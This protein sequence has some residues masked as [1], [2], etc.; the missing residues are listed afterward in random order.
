MTDEAYK[1]HVFLREIRKLSILM[2][3]SELEQKDWF[4][5]AQGCGSYSSEL[6]VQS[7][8]KG[9]AMEAAIVKLVE[10]EEEHERMLGD[11]LAK[12]QTALAM[13]EDLTADEISILKLYY[14]HRYT[15]ESISGIIHLSRQRVNQIR[16]QAL[17]SIGRKMA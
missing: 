6:K 16:H 8:A 4:N 10:L 11:L 9:D 1:A 7:S 13:F 12:M 5:K 14:F 15:D 3:I 2:A 17:G